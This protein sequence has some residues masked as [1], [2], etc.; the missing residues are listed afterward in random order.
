MKIKLYNAISIDGFIAKADGDS[1]WVDDAD[2]ENYDSAIAAA[3]VVIVGRKTY[4]QFE[5]DLYEADDI[6]TIVVTGDPEK[7]EN[8]VEDEDVVA[9]HPDPNAIIDFLEEEDFE[10]AVLIGGGETNGLFMNMG[11]VDEVQVVVHPIIIGDGIRL[12]GD[13]DGDF[14]T[15]GYSLSKVTQHESGIVRILYTRE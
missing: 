5:G 2:F 15:L 6:L 1:D 9:M 14:E 10:G 4:E 11:L 7:F 3:G 8:S 13:I 12:F